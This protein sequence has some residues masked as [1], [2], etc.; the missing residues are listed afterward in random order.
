[1][2]NHARL[3]GT[4]WQDHICS[5]GAGFCVVANGDNRAMMMIAE[6]AQCLLQHAYP[7]FEGLDVSKF[8]KNISI[9]SIKQVCDYAPILLLRAWVSLICACAHWV[10]IVLKCAFCCNFTAG[11]DCELRIQKYGAKTFEFT[12]LWF[13]FI[14]SFVDSTD[15]KGWS[16]LFGLILV[17]RSST[18]VPRTSTWPAGNCPRDWPPACP[19]AVSRSHTRSILARLDPSPPSHTRLTRTPTH[20]LE[21]LIFYIKFLNEK[22]RSRYEIRI[23]CALRVLTTRLRDITWVPF[24]LSFLLKFI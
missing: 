24:F 18:G 11:G 5:Q 12:S 17:I 21:L 15:A 4:I 16:H 20:S 1:M 23:T 19:I 10:F 9:D 8:V 2:C 7:G 14:H 6:I 22:S 3:L 13:A